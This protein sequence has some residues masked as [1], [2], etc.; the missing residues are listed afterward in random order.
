MRL[1][2][3]PPTN[4]NQVML[5]FVTGPALFPT[6][7]LDELAEERYNF[8]E[9]VVCF[10]KMASVAQVPISIPEPYRGTCVNKVRSCNPRL[11]P[12]HQE[13]YE[14]IFDESNGGSPFT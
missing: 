2:E 3:Q 13:C 7:L 6:D 12:S 4:Q 11:K 9:T 1:R 10:D 14:S 8:H 5:Q